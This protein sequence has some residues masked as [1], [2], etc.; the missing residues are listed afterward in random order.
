M[1]GNSAGWAKSLFK[2]TAIYLHV[3]VRIHVTIAT[4]YMYKP[5]RQVNIVNK[6]F[7]SATV[8]VCTCRCGLHL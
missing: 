6:M 8:A 3:H 7:Y 4:R 2:V 5:D 1:P